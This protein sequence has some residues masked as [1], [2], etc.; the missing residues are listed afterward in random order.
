VDPTSTPVEA[1][2]ESNSCPL[3]PLSSA[4]I[5]SNQIYNMQDERGEFEIRTQRRKM[6][7]IMILF[8]KIF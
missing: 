2:N 5:E 3:A 6:T 1:H 7:Y 8:Q 4:D